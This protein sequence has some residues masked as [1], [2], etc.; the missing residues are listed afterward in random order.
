MAVKLH[1]SAF[2]HAQKLI[3]AGHVVVDDRDA[4]H[5]SPSSRPS[6]P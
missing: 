6:G 1:K 5:A 4:D 3:N 2:D